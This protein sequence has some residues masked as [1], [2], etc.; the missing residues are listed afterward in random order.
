MTA[1]RWTPRPLA[2]ADLPGLLAVQRACY[3]EGFVESA[4]VFARRLASPVNC[5]LVL[6]HAGK[7]CAYLAAYRSHLNKVTPLHGDFG[8]DRP[9]APGRAAAPA[10]DT[11]YLHDMAVLPALAGQG[12]ARA[13]LAPVWERAR[14]E[15]LRHSALVS[16]QGSQGYWERH[17]YAVQP[18]ADAAQR[19]HLASYGEGA[20]YMVRSL[21]HSPG[22][23][24]ASVSPR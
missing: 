21:L 14:Q 19:E 15:G 22:G 5:S 2:A 3:G 4:E 8:A 20:V 9:T 24:G 23:P 7:V 10:P 6:E 18:L 17:G 12:L 16:V 13:L 1:A 11:L